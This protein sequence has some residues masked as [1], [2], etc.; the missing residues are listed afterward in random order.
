MIGVA[1]LGVL[2]FNLT[3]HTFWGNEFF[4]YSQHWL[5]PLV[6]LLAGNLTWDG[7]WGRSFVAASAVLVVAVAFN[8]VSLMSEIFATIETWRV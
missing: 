7:R 1:A 2:A 4:I 5:V 6:L 3:L 8:S